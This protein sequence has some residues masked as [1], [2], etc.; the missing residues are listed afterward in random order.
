MVV[1]TLQ[2][3]YEIIVGMPVQLMYLT[4]VVILQQQVHLNFLPA[5]CLN[6]LRMQLR[7]DRI[8]IRMFCPGF[9]L[10]FY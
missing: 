2:D 7:R 4:V 8:D 6:L 10:T 9:N 3:K 1:V 5:H